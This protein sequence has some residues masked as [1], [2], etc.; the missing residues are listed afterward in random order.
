MSSG[1]PRAGRSGTAWQ[2]AT[3][4]ATHNDTTATTVAV[5]LLV[6]R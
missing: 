4:T 2:P 1:E 6:I 3:I 5:T